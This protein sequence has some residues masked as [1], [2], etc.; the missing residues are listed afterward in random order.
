[1]K[2]YT[3]NNL[4]SNK[5]RKMYGLKYSYVTGGMYGGIASKELVSKM[6]LNGFLS[7]LGTGGMSFSQ[8]KDSIQYIKHHSSDKPFGIN[9]LFNHPDSE[10]E[11][12][13]INLLLQLEI[14]FLEAASFICITKPLVKY[15]VKGIYKDSKGQIITPNNIFIKAS[16]SGIIKQFLEPI[17]ELYL[18]QLIED[19]VITSYQAELAKQIPLSNN[20]IFEADSGGHSDNRPA[21]AVFPVIK[22]LISQYKYNYNCDFY[23]GLA[24]GLGTPESIAAAFIMGAD[25][26]VTGSI[27]QCT[28]ES[29][30]PSIVK[31]MLSKSGVEDFDTCPT[32]DM[33]NTEAK[34]QVL[35][36]GTLFST[37]AK[38]LIQVYNKYDSIEEIDEKTKL[39]IENN[40]FKNSLDEVYEVCK[41]KLPS[42]I[43]QKG[44]EN[45]HNKMEIIFRQY[46]SQSIKH[47]YIDGK[48]DDSKNFQ[49][50]SGP[51]M[52]AFNAYVKNTDLEKWQNRNV[53]VIALKLLTDTCN[54]ISEY[55]N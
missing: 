19:G 34:I 9:V 46:F 35:K 36:K 13:I 25:F 51:A 27:N 8:I 20:I 37:R 4:G 29:G 38:K 47:T 6:S 14:N 24:G 22:N 1:M 43:L 18:N 41:R 55:F 44:D 53:D 10:K 54:V 17:P 3:P 28:P 39:D 32:G 42:E 15:R 11:D 23:L 7:F 33:F 12:S 52:G 5:F 26:V 30:A 40:Y 31:E 45:P 16:R 21:I 49:I 2:R 48:A 50:Y